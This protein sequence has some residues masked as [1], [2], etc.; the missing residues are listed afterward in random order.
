[1]TSNNKLDRFQI[2]PA[3]ERDDSLASL[4]WAALKEAAAARES[5]AEETRSETEGELAAREKQG[6]QVARELGLLVF[7][8]RKSAGRQKKRRRHGEEHAHLLAVGERALERQ[9]VEIHDPLGEPLTEEL[10]QT[11]EV[12]G[13]VEKPRIK[14]DVVG[15][16][17]EPVIRY[18]GKIINFAKVVRWVGFSREKPVPVKK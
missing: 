12:V 9:G 2:P 11:V 3:G 10:L 14:G 13:T 8:T 5:A 4:A 1:M 16:T 7:E 6:D 15:E 17:L 18:R